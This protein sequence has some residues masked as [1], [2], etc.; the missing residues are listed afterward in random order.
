MTMF[1]G[2]VRV[3]RVACSLDGSATMRNGDYYPSRLRAQYDAAIM[4]V[5][6]K[7]QAHGQSTVGLVM[8]SGRGY[9]PPACLLPVS[10]WIALVRA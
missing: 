8:F 10:S 5:E 2:G 3:R 1:F 4:V 7:L 9:V 6:T